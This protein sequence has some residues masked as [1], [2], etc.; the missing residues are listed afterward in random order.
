[1]EV[2]GESAGP[3]R[4]E[5]AVPEDSSRA[6]NSASR[7]HAQ[8][9]KGRKRRTRG[10]RVSDNS[11]SDLDLTV[12]HQQR[13]N[14]IFFF[15]TENSTSVAD[16]V[17]SA[18][19]AEASGDDEEVGRSRVRCDPHANEGQSE[20]VDQPVPEVAT[21]QSPTRDEQEA[22]A[23]IVAPTDPRLDVLGKQVYLHGLVEE[24]Y[25]WHVGLCGSEVLDCCGRRDPPSLAAPCCSLAKIGSHAS[26]SQ[27]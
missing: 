3:Q 26:G 14:G 25:N 13:Q 17:Q 16:Q 18:G 5:G 2:K 19:V 22:G 1:M 15:P 20:K 9:H 21:T 11:Q 6:S 8:Q 27:G 24:R 4:A 12:L 10:R 23:T 7:V